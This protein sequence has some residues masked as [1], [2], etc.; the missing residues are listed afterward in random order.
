MTVRRL[1]L[2]FGVVVVL[3]FAVL[4]WTGLRIYQQAPPVP[5][6][7]VTT[8]GQ[9]LLEPGDIVA[10]QNLWQS[11]GGM[12]VGSVWGHGSYVAPDWTADWLHREAIFILDAWAGGPG[13]YADRPADERAALESRLQ[14]TMRTNTFDAASGTL[15]IAPVRAQAFAANLA[16]YS[17]VFANGRDEYAIP[18]GAVSDPQHLRQLSAFFFWTAWAA[19][20]NRPGDTVTYTSNWPHE[21]LVGNRPTGDA[22]VWTGVSILLLLAGIGGMASYYASRREEAPAADAPADDPLLGAV[23][24]RRSGRR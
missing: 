4:G 17:D 22:I 7:V 20:T 14:T 8:D 19:T 9:T 23:A 13:Q 5:D 3:S 10:G 2:A 15:T 12:E 16:H 6:R 11:M 1:W 21:P 24:L 18:A